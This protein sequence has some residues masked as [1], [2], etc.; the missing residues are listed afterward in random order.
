MHFFEKVS[1]TI[2]ILW[3]MG[4]K[5]VIYIM[6]TKVAKY[7]D[8]GL[9]MLH[10][11]YIIC[12]VETYVM[13]TYIWKYFVSMVYF[14]CLIGNKFRWNDFISNDDVVLVDWSTYSTPLIQLGF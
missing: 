13:S 7:F 6:L 1:L 3:N 5:N 4:K 11:N 12:K 9:Y 2:F 14:Y 10:W 8:I